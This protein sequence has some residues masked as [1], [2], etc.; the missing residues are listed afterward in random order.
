MGNS[1]AFEGSEAGEGK[2]AGHHLVCPK[3]SALCKLIR[4]DIVSETG[5]TP[6]VA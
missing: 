1:C 5:D 4:G 2:W 6:A 3:D